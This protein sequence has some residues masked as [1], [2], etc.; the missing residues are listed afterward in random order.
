MLNNQ[1]DI[2]TTVP[3]LVNFVW[4][5]SD[6]LL[7]FQD[8]VSYTKEIVSFHVQTVTMNTPVHKNV[9]LVMKLVLPVTVIWITNVIPVILH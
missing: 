6:V 8:Q 5:L 3:I 7:V 9:E 2:V 4:M 1:S